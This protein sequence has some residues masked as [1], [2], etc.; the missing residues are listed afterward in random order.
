MKKEIYLDH[1]ATT[2]MWPEVQAVMEPYLS[3]HYGNASTAYELGKD[4]K[5]AME[6]ARGTIAQCLEAEPEEIFFT[7]GGSE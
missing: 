7:S 5:K 2:R 3:E 6:N 1:A 4:A